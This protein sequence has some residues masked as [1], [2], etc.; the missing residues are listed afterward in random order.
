MKTIVSMPFRYSS[1]ISAKYGIGSTL[2]MPLPL[3]CFFT[4]VSVASLQFATVAILPARVTHSSSRKFP[5]R[6]NIALSLLESALN[7]LSIS[8]SS[9]FWGSE[10]LIIGPRLS[11]SPQAQSAGTSIVAI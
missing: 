1:A 7:A 4:K 9:I 2:V 10:G 3:L 6:N 8:L 5:P 11:V